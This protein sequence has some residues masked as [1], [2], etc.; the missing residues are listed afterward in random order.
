MLWSSP[1]CSKW[2]YLLSNN[3]II[4]VQSGLLGVLRASWREQR[5]PNG[6]T[7]QSLVGGTT[8]HDG[9]DHDD[10]DGYDH[11]DD[12]GYDHDDDDADADI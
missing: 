8:D 3:I 7:G 11:D 1:S 6:I 9:D 4:L 12:D 10:D 2:S 5:G